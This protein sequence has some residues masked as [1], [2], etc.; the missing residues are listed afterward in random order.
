MTPEANCLKQ[1][2]YILPS[3]R[4]S[5]SN[6]T[7]PWWSQQGVVRL[8]HV[9]RTDDFRQLEGKLCLKEGGMSWPNIWACDSWVVLWACESLCV[10]LS[11]C[12]S[13]TCTPS[14][15]ETNKWTHCFSYLSPAASSLLPPISLLWR[16][17][18]HN[19]RAWRRQT[20]LVISSDPNDTSLPKFGFVPCTWACAESCDF[21]IDRVES[22]MWHRRTVIRRSRLQPEQSIA[23]YTDAAVSPQLPDATRS[24]RRTCAAAASASLWSVEAAC[25]AGFVSIHNGIST[26]LVSLGLVSRWSAEQR[27]SRGY[28][29]PGR[30][31][32]PRPQP[33]SRLLVCLCR[34]ISKS[35]ISILR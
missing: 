3:G 11:P 13:I 28:R 2:N 4:Y 24:G 26:Y 22:Y 14:M 19:R 5:I 7:T 20:P 25:R 30:I 27:A 8:S 15:N 1:N 16:R 9:R 6:S 12:T 17:C 32:C 34:V 31:W 18:R 21:Y 23:G 10:G 35:L 33:T 29:A